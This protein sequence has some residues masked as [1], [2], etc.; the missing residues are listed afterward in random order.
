MATLDNTVYSD[1]LE[2]M[3]LAS[4]QSIAF[5]MEK[6]AINSNKKAID[7]QQQFEA[8]LDINS[9]DSVSPWIQNLQRG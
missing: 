8:A 5:E 2:Q 3:Q 4:E 7:T 9:L 6:D 1:V